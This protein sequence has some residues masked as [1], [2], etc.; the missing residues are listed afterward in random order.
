MFSRD[1][2]AQGAEPIKGGEVI[3]RG[4]RLGA[5]KKNFSLGVNPQTPWDEQRRTVVSRDLAKDGAA[6]CITNLCCGRSG[7]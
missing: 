3:G 7:V 6:V 5:P 1:H 4:A 2:P